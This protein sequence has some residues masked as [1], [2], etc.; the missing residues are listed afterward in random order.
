LAAI[1]RP[2]DLTPGTDPLAGSDSSALVVLKGDVRIERDGARAETASAGDVV[3]IYETLGGVTLPVR[4]E[5]VTPGHGLRFIRS[6]VIDVLAD[7]IGLLRSI[8]SGLLRV[9]EATSSPHVHE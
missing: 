3:G 8:F 5:V 6:E 9:P 4:A 2:V 7:D 1:A